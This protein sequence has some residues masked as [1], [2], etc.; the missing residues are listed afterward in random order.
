V[1]TDQGRGR[2]GAR[3]LGTG[4]DGQAS[5]AALL[6]VE[7]VGLVALVGLIALAGVPGVGRGAIALGGVVAIGLAVRHLVVVDQA[8]RLA[9]RAP[10]RPRARAH[11]CGRW[12][13]ADAV[14]QETSP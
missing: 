9:R 5:R 3:G 14:H 6:G 8:R 1:D 11:R 13:T 10:A 2:A 4:S 7:G 12:R